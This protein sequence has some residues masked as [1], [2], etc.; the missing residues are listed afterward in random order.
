MGILGKVVGTALNAVGA[1]VEAGVKKLD[2]LEKAELQ[3][4][5]DYVNNS[6]YKNIY[7]IK[8]V[9]LQDA[10]LGF[11]SVHT[12]KVFNSNGKCEYIIK[13][14]VASDGRKYKVLDLNG[15]EIGTVVKDRFNISL[16]SE[17]DNRHCTINIKGEGGFGIET[18]YNDSKWNYDRGFKIRMTCSSMSI[19]EDSDCKIYTIKDKIG[20]NG[21]T[22]VISIYNCFYGDARYIVCFNDSKYKLKAIFIAFGLKFV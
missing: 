11:S 9:G 14:K 17:K 3:K 16:G 22:E 19:E 8:Y 2:E 20:K 7:Y 12:F 18:Y 6:S 10:A 5:Q 13:E 1:V 21:K 15:N 4:Q